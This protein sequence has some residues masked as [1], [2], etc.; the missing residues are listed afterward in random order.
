MEYSPHHVYVARV[1]P[2]SD[3]D[4]AS[5]WVKPQIGTIKVTVDVAI[6]R[7]VLSSDLV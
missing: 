1:S 5:K 2:M 6:L 7:I 3:G 4:G